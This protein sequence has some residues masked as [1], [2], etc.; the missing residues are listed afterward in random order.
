MSLQ[1]R[2]ETIRSSPSP[3]NEEAAKIRILVP[4]LQSLGWDPHGPDVLYEHAVGGKGGGRAD[5]ALESPRRVV[6][7]IEAKAPGADLRNH[8]DQVLGYAFLEGV[9]ICALT[10][11]LEWWLYLPRESGPPPERLFAVLKTKE[12]PVEQLVED[13]NA[14]LSKEMLVSGQAERRAKDVLKASHEAARLNKEIPN[15]WQ[16]M[17]GEPDD[18]L[19]ELLAK[20][21]YEKLS[22][23]PTRE[24]VIA[25]L[26]GSDVPSAP[27]RGADPPTAPSAPTQPQA[28]GKRE[29]PAPSKKPTAI[30]LW[31]KRHEVKSHVDALR[32][33]IDRLHERHSGEF[34]R[35][36]EV[37][38]N[39]NP[40]A[41][42]NPQEFKPAG[43]KYYYEHAPSGYFFDL[44]HDAKGLQRRARQFLAHFGHDPS[45]LKIIYD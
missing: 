34:D 19:V 5:I 17:L 27:V 10:T 15:I 7:L 11:G 28:S 4:I 36:L 35:V 33:V 1:E 42:R 44:W 41:A 13:L 6:A 29:S 21:V 3:P 43:R 26:Q 16:R 45:D 24:Q 9:D 8:V 25:V 14:F 40:Y 18:E 23:R 20:R 38:G 12:D 32:T 22:L 39:K 31:G 2:L 37:R 30:E